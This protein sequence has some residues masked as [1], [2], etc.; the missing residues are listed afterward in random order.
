MASYFS[1]LADSIDS[2]I[3]FLGESIV[4]KMKI[5]IEDESRISG[6]IEHVN[7][8]L[9]DSEIPALK[10]KLRQIAVENYD[11]SIIATQM[12]EAY[13]HFLLNDN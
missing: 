2:L 3:P 11:W 1:G 8:V 4:N 13:Q 6:L 12:I 7:S 5:S 10:P 9:K